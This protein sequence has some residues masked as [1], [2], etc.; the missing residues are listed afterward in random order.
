MLIDWDR[1]E[2]DLPAGREAYAAAQPFPHL[3]LDDVLLPE[4][5]D[6]AAGEFPGLRD[7]LWKGYLHVNETKYSHT[8]SRTRGDRPCA[9][10]R[11][12]SARRGSSR[13]SRS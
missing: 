4:V 13:T 12:T 7:E 11:R 5:F 3:V 9:P 10:S 8:R 1:L 6:E 2:A